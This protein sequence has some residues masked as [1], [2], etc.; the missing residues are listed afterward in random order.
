MPAK[1]KSNSDDNVSIGNI[2]F[3]KKRKEHYEK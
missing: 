1:T 2:G 3:S